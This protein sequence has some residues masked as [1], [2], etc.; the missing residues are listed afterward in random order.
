MGIFDKI[1]KPK[2]EKLIDD[3]YNDNTE[4][5][6]KAALAL[7]SM[8][9]PIVEPLIEDLKHRDSCLLVEYSPSDV[10]SA[11]G[12]PAIKPLIRILKDSK[13]NPLLHKVAASVAALALARMSNRVNESLFRRPKDSDLEILSPTSV[14]ISGE[15]LI[16][17]ELT[18]AV[19]PLIQILED[20]KCE[21]QA[22]I[23]GACMAL[24]NIGDSRAIEP[25]KRV[26]EVWKDDTLILTFAKKALEK[27]Q[28]NWSE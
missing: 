23:M 15:S 12:E 4:V 26:L 20:G 22:L 5:R 14:K 16:A 24:E 9:E 25:L 19:G 28:K 3:R 2:T 8:G 27:I 10:L 18:N 6:K 17:F 7:I 13:S 21:N 11:V 1:F